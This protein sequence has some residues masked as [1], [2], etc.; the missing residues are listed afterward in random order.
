VWP[1]ATAGSLLAYQY[2]PANG[3]FYMSAT[4][5]AAVPIATTSKETTIYLP[6]NVKGTVTVAGS[7]K[8]DTTTRAPDGSRVA[9]VAPSGG[10]NG[11]YTISVGNPSASLKS[12]VQAA[13][14][15]PLPPISEPAARQ[16]VAATIAAAPSSSNAKVRSNASEVSLLESLL[17]GTT[18]PNG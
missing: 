15:N 5:P 4:D 8:L 2:E 10:A 7:A 9:F 16:V 17:L 11:A 1:R 14:A 3:S 6:P 12:T 13:A 18:D